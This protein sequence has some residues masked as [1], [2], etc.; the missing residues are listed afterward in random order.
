MGAFKAPIKHKSELYVSLL[1]IRVIFQ[2]LLVI[3]QCINK[4]AWETNK[5]GF[6]YL[7]EVNGSFVLFRIVIKMLNDVVVTS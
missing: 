5:I 4:L 1:V 7:V 2:V 6:I 3:S